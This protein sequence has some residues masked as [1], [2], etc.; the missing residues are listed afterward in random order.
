MNFTFYI[1][2]AI[3]IIST[4]MV[5][6]GVNA[7]HALLYF[8]VSLLSV[9]V[10]FYILGAPFAAALI[11]II[12][13]GAIMVLFVFVIMMLNLGP[14]TAEQEKRWLSPRACAGPVILTAILVVELVY[15]LIKK[16]AG[17][18]G[19][20]VVSAKEVGIA[21]FGPYL[22]GVELASILLLA[23]L[24]GAYHLGRKATNNEEENRD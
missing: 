13:A 12:N 21:L 6:A 23:G 1:C 11:V 16:G 14:Q 17:I 9:G 8:I 3:A 4:V 10:I 19:A 24:I 22:L 2:A 20:A 15:A 5:I 18:A 7:V